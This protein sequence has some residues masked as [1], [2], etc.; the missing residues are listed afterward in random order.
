MSRQVQLSD[1]AYRLLRARKGRHESF[2]DVVVRLV[3]PKGDPR[4]LFGLGR[5][6]DRETYLRKMEDA[7]RD[8][9]TTL[10]AHTRARR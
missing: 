4:A 9:R 3:R 6:D 8:R 5:I 7:D 10:E 1:E 2:S